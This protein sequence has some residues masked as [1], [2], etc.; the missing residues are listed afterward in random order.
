MMIRCSE[1]REVEV[2]SQGGKG[3]EAHR[4][5]GVCWRRLVAQL[6]VSSQQLAFSSY[7]RI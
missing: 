3:D 4:A 2:I 1:P 7:D 5:F 6:A